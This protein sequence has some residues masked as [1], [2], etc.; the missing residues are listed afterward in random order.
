MESSSK[1]EISSTLASLTE[2]MGKLNIN[3][4]SSILST[5]S[6]EKIEKRG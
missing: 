5:K 4:E 6:K 3:D 1:S 2:E